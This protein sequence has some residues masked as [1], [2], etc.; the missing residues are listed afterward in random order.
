M[1][2]SW[3]LLGPIIGYSFTGSNDSRSHSLRPIPLDANIFFY[4]NWAFKLKIVF[5]FLHFNAQ[6]YF[7]SKIILIFLFLLNFIQNISKIQLYGVWHVYFWT[8]SSFVIF[9]FCYITRKW[10]TVMLL[11]K[12]NSRDFIINKT[13]YAIGL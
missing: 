4:L 8:I 12:C 10:L 6:K 5:I 3:P 9:F 7:F 1:R 13:F 2:A 11:P